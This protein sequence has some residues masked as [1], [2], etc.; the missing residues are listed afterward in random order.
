MSQITREQLEELTR[1]RLPF[2]KAYRFVIENLAA[3]EAWVR[4][5]ANGEFLRPGGT[6]SGPAMMAL[7]DYAMYAA[8]L[9]TIGPVE[10]AV[11]T[12]LN[13]NFLHK[14]EPGDLVAKARLIK[15]GKR[16]AV[17][18]VPIFGGDGS[19]MVAHATATYSIP[20]QRQPVR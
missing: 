4:L 15:L 11:T 2:A 18:D 19:V 5:P 20:P 9:A 17:G 12:N 13:I 1:E 3:H 10:L 6:I 14:P 7:A 16:L 8:I